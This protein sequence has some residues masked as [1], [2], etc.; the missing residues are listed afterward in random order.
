[1]SMLALFRIIVTQFEKPIYTLAYSRTTRS[2]FILANSIK[3]RDSTHTEV[4]QGNY[5]SV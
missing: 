4:S 2:T 5:N 3:H 1:L